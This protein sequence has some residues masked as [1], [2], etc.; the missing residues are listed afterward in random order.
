MRPARMRL[1]ASGSSSRPISWAIC[2]SES[3]FHGPASF[4]HMAALAASGS[5]TE[6]TPSRLTP[7]RM[8]GSTLALAIAVPAVIPQLA[9]LA[10]YCSALTTL[11]SRSPPTVST[12]PA[13]CIFSNGLSTPS[14]STARSITCEAPSCSR[15]GA[16]SSLRVEAATV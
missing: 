5:S 15:N 1:I 14:A 6:S 16:C 4:S 12:A 11:N 2:S 9:T 3:S 13:H 10:P 7:R 8:N